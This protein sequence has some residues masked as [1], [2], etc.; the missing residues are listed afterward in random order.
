MF[1]VVAPDVVQLSVLI[2][3]SEILVGLAVNELMVGRVGG[4]TVTT[5]VAVAEPV[6][7]V[8]VK[9]YVVVAVGLRTTVPLADVDANVPGVMATL[10]APAVAQ[11]TVVVEPLMIDA[12]LTEKELMVGA[13]TCLRVGSFCVQPAIPAK[14]A[15]NTSAGT[16][17]RNPCR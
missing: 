8:A 13:A 2:P 9:V 14:A 4:V 16:A 6:V 5:N 11:L 10:V 1:S 12:G 7:F 17:V 3:P 15:R